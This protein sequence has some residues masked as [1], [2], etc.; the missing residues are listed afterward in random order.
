ML[1]M[2]ILLPLLTSC[3]RSPS[4]T[5]RQ[6]DNWADVEVRRIQPIRIGVALSTSGAGSEV[7]AL[8]IFQAAELAARDAGLVHG[9]PVELVEFNTQC[10]SAGGRS[11]A[12]SIVN[13][14]TL[15]AVIGPGCNE[16]CEASKTIFESAH[17]TFVSPACSGETSDEQVANG[18]AY[19]HTMY[20]SRLDAEIAAY[21]AYA[22][23]GARRVL[24]IDDGQ[25][26]T[27]ANL[28]AFQ[29]RFLDQE[30]LP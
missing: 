4:E 25:T 26:G 14:P 12:L 18:G 23:I 7:E 9:Y 21:F 29:A 3:A 16:A 5:S 8:D 19:L 27:S 22:E 11:A 15:V 2:S 30:A 17:Y 10:S 24:L 28:A 6:P 13:D 1:I 20:D